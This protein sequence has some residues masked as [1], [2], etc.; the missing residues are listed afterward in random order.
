MS[1]HMRL[2]RRH[3]LRVRERQPRR[4]LLG[5]GQR[6][7]RRGL[8][9]RR[10]LRLRHQIPG[11]PAIGMHPH[12]GLQLGNGRLHVT[13]GD[14]R[15]DLPRRHALR[16]RRTRRHQKHRKNRRCPSRRSPHRN[17]H[18]HGPLQMVIPPENQPAPP[19][20]AKT[21]RPRPITRNPAASPCLPPPASRSQFFAT[22][23]CANRTNNNH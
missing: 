12:R 14:L 13:A 17:L 7:A 2:Q 3:I 22:R 4:E 6:R 1:T 10:V 18:K 8:V 20:V 16:P 11:H 15:L 23:P 21:P 19:P 5:L 9:A